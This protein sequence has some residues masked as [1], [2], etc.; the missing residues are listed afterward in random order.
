MII[1]NNQNSIND[2]NDNKNNHNDKVVIIDII[3]ITYCTMVCVF[4]IEQM[5][6]DLK[7]H[8]N[9]DGSGLCTLNLSTFRGCKYVS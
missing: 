5:I 9:E 1:N 8:K 7:S 3:F 2:D 4:I 6:K